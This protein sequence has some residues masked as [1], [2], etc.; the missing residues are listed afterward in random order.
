LCVGCVK[1]GESEEVQ[2]EKKMAK[3]RGFTEGSDMAG[4]PDGI[5]IFKPKLPIWVLLWKMLV[6]FVSIWSILL[7]F[8]ILYGHLVNFPA[9]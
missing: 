9:I 1:W 2:K 3:R 7:P 5:R 4:L 8:G 6:Y